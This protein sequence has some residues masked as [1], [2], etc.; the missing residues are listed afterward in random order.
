MRSKLLF[1]LIGGALGG[2]AMKAVVATVDKNAFGLST[3]TD[4]KAARALTR[5]FGLPVPSREEAVVLGA[6][7]HYTFALGA[8][9][10]YPLC[11]EAFPSI[12][13]AKGAAF[14]TALWLIGDELLVW[15]TGLENPAH[16]PLK[17]HVSAL[18]AHI[19]FGIVVETLVSSVERNRA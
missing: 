16:V 12:R 6:A 3:G 8:G 18:G 17:S 5:Q 10:A 4:V 15:I 11:A 19:I 13:F 2:V 7:M 1:G 9:L 14:G